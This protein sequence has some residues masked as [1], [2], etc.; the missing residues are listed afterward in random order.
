MTDMTH[1]SGAMAA[2]A[3]LAI[4]ASEGLR[5]ENFGTTKPYLTRYLEPCPPCRAA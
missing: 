5:A 2:Q 1:E 3:R 4:L